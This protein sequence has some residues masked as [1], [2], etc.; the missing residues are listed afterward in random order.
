MATKHWTLLLKP[1]QIKPNHTIPNQ[2]KQ[3]PRTNCDWN[4]AHTHTRLKYAVGKRGG[5]S[6][7]TTHASTEFL[8][9][10]VKFI[11]KS[12]A[13]LWIYKVQ[14][15][16]MFSLS[17]FQIDEDYQDRMKY[18]LLSSLL[19][20]VRHF[21]SCAFPKWLY[22]GKK[23]VWLLATVGDEVSGVKKKA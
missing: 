6:A 11:F 16:L 15:A 19:N 12:S 9:A 10:F 18:A 20:A 8:I 21:F 7:K 2:T 5:E 14:S 1:Q 22:R 4:D 23:R 17:D 13:C 3:I